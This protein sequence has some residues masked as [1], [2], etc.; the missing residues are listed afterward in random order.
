MTTGTIDQTQSSD[1]FG[2]IAN[3]PLGE[4]IADQLREMILAGELSAG[5]PLVEVALAAE[6]GVSRAPMREALRILGLDGLVET[7]PYRGT[8][9]R[10]LKRR[11][12]EELRTIRTLHEGFAVRRIVARGDRA[13]LDRLYACCDA[14]AGTV[15]D[16]IALDRADARFHATLIDLAQHGLLN[17]FWRTIAIQVRQVMAMS[18]RRIA[19]AALIASNHRAIVDAMAAGDASSAVRLLEGHVGDVIDVVLSDWS[20]P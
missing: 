4:R 10:G 19:D 14:M 9:V 8:T 6:F 5:A 7:V 2:E 11:D 17:T 1:T 12:V 13:A 18:N 15:G 16:R 3:V 20:E